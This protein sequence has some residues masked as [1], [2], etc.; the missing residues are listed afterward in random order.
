MT[1]HSETDGSAIHIYKQK[2]DL[3]CVWM[4]E[5]WDVFATE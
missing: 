1:I 2:R 4:C 5:T 3:G